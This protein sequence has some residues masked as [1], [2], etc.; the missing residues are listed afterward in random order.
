MCWLEKGAT[1]CLSVPSS[2]PAV[3]R[4]QLVFASCVEMYLFRS[5]P[6]GVFVNLE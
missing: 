1:G 3:T 2:L 5:T 4:L 6:L